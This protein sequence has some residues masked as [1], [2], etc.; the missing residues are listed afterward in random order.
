M[1][2]AG[3]S[4]P[5]IYDIARAAGVNPSTVSRA[6]NRPGRVSV[7]LGERIR[8]I[9]DQMDYHAN[10]NARALPTGRTRT[11][12]FVVA[13][14]TNP[15]IF[16]VIR[17]AEQAVTRHDYT[18]ILVDSEESTKQEN[19]NAN[20][21]MR[22]VDCLILANTRLSDGDIRYL[23]ERK[24]VVLVNRQLDGVTSITPEIDKGISEL[25]DHLVA[26]GHRTIGF[27]AGPAQS[28]MSA[29]RAASL[30]ARAEWAKLTLVDLGSEAP[31]ID[32]G[33]AA[34]GRVVRS[35]VTAVVAFNDL[36]A[37]GLIQELSL[38]GVSIPDDLSIV[39]F[40]DIFGADFVTPS[41]TTI[42]S[43]LR[44]MGDMAVEAGLSLTGMRSVVEG[45]RAPTINTRLVVRRSVAAPRV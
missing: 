15:M 2:E 39:G 14:I 6:L 7:R 36:M 11:V 8:A 27:L 1:S 26:V 10:P 42:A 31:T 43:P 28:W 45:V 29:R 22:S 3:A 17:G 19:L 32:G 16:D 41:L 33:R 21:I 13:D 5:T 4:P 24:A 44:E 20:R 34:A 37:I 35:P 9:A 18:L 25:I 23:A 38:G 12:G 30:K 40:D